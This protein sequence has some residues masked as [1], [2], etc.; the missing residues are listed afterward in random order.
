MITYIVMQTIHAVHTTLFAFFYLDSV[1]TVNMFYCE[2]VLFFSK[3][4]EHISKQLKRLNT[5]NVK[6][7]NNR[8]LSRL[9][10]EFNRVVFELKEMNDLF[11]VRS[12]R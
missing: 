11:K 9:I 4:F 7:I 8:K 5:S 12:F 2:L 3:K 1:Y 6:I 10:Y